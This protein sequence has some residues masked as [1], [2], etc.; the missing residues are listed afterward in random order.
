METTNT[1]TETA[2][3]VKVKIA[4]EMAKSQVEDFSEE[5]EKSVKEML[6]NGVMYGHRKTK[7]NPKFKKYIFANRNNIEIIDL[8]KTMPAIETAAQF[9][10]N[11]I[12]DNKLILLV[13]TQPAGHSTIEGMAEKFNFPCVKNRWIGGLIT[14]FKV[15]SQRLEY[16]KK[17]QADIESGAFEKYTKKERVM[18]NKSIEKMKRIFGGLEKL[19]KVPDILFVIDSSLKGHAIAVR[20][21]KKAKIPVV[22]IIDS[23][24]N[25]EAIDFPIPAN[26]HAK[27][28]IEWV[29][30]RI[31]AKLQD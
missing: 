10:K 8:L 22:A 23:D 12:K 7:T 20:E 25:P 16:F 31:I 28:S 3:E 5:D 29:V 30:N 9:L 13:S 14:N 19:T 26:D 2:S 27:I 17:T 1:D 15:V 4:E 24:D 18:I 21:A 11:S 6:K